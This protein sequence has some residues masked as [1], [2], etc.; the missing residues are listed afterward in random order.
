M[1]FK[2]KKLIFLS[3]LLIL[4]M[5]IGYSAISSSLKIDSTAKVEANT[6]NITKEIIYKDGNVNNNQVTINDDTLTFSSTLNNEYDYYNFIIKV[7]NKGTIDASLETL[8]L[9]S[10]TQEQQNLVEYQITYT[11]GTKIN[12]GDILP[13]GKTTKL[14]VRVEYKE[15]ITTY[16]TVNLNNLTLTLK[17][18]IADKSSTKEIP[19]THQVDFYI[20]KEDNTYNKTTKTLSIGSIL[21]VLAP[22]LT[23]HDFKGWSNKPNGEVLYEPGSTY[24]D[25][26]AIK[27]YTIFELSKY[28]INFELNGG[29]GTFTTIQ[30]TYGED[31]QL[32]S[33]IPS[34]TGYTFKGWS[35]NNKDIEYQAGEPFSLNEDT[36]LYAIWEA[37]TY[38][39]VYNGNGSTAGSMTNST[40]TY[41]IAKNLTANGFSRAYTVTFNHN[42]TGSTNTT[43]TATYTFKNWNTNAAGTGT[44][45]TNSESV[46]NLATSGTFNLYAQWNSA[47]VT[48]VPTR[49]GY[50]FGGWYAETGCTTNKAGTNG[51]FTP[52]SN[53]TLYAKWT[54]N[55]YTVAYNG[56]GSTAGSMTNSTHTYDTAKNLTANAYTKTGYSFSGWATSANG[57]VAYTNGQSVTNLA[58]SGTVTLYAKWTIN[59]YILTIN[60]N[61]GTW[62]NSTA[63]QTAK[64]NYGT[65]KTVANPTRTGY[66]F[67]GWTTSGTC[68][69]SVTTFTYGAGDCT[70]TANWTPNTYTV[71]Y[72]GNGNTGGSMTNSTH[73]YDTA[74]NLTTNAYTKTGYS[75]SGWATSA[76]GNVAYTNSQSVTNLAT[77]GT[78]TLYAKWTINKYTLTFNANNG[79]VSPTSITQ[80][81]GTSL[82]LPTPTRSGYNFLGWYTAA[83]GGTK[84]TYT[85]MPAVSETLYAQWSQ[86]TTIYFTNGTS[87]SGGG[88]GSGGSTSGGNGS[89]T[90][91]NLPIGVIVYYTLSASGTTN[92]GS[93]SA[94]ITY[95]GTIIDSISTNTTGTTSKSGSFTTTTSGKL[96]FGGGGGGGPNGGGGGGCTITKITDANGN[97]Y[98]LK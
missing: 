16:Q 6:W 36:T 32:P 85:T 72:N 79:T 70:I 46:T 80:N 63:T 14:L 94:S 34:K 65:T 77:S 71:V 89:E 92:S 45:Y 57:N 43:R 56:N 17:Y 11:D 35:S 49:T 97:K 87:A 9:S 44:T 42:Y 62:S 21:D 84:R 86:I 82:T 76:N 25:N 33:T 8:N 40:H 7:E 47:S 60:P 37:N 23:G 29:T 22:T 95:D 81:Y 28:D 30:K 73:T 26:Y 55:T 98:I 53:I 64:Q 19:T 38:T 3:L 41:D 52:T 31:I 59:S 67:G 54:P 48:Y 69:L 83:S 75:F 13:A 91:D 90:V 66:T 27:L 12:I 15:N 50:T 68:N 74:K 2:R 93:G 20:L 96:S 18:K 61:G 88:G 10:L 39:V 1:K 4:I 5:G 24:N 78:V 58:T 51:V